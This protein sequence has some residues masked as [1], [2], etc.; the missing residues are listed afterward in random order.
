M[1]ITDNGLIAPPSGRHGGYVLVLLMLGYVLSFFDRQ[2]LVMM[3][4]PIGRDLHLTD[5]HF[6][7]LYGFA[8]AFF[9]TVVGLFFGRLVDSMHRPRLLAGAIILWSLATAACGLATN[10][11]ELFIARMMVGVGEA[12]LAPV[13]Y[14][15]IADLFQPQRR[16]R[17]FSIYAMGIYL[18]TGVAFILGGKLVGW[19]DALPPMSLPWNGEPL[20]GWHLA[21]LIAGVPGLVLALALMFV[22][23]ARPAR[24]AATPVRGA[25]F[26]SF[27]EHARRHWRALT[28]H[29]FGFAMHTGYGYAIAIWT[30]AFFLRHHHWSIGQVGLVLG[31]I[32]LTAGP[33]G[34]IA[35]G[36]LTDAWLK[37]GIKDA[38][39]RVGSL[40]CVAQLGAVALMVLSPSPILGVIG[41]ALAI[42]TMAATAGPAG[43]ALQQL[44]PATLRGQAGAFYTLVANLLG[45]SLVPLLVGLSTDRLFVDPSK[46]GLSLLAVGAF[47]LLLGAGLLW[48]GKDKFALRT[49]DAQV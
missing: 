12:A 49:D 36:V 1:Q 3:I 9:Y 11:T 25:T 37:R 35:G 41:A 26:G 33:L 2:I 14:S 10:F 48:L 38:Y 47:V 18:G 20:A 24:T 39:L 46:V 34:A 4:E 40:I 8:F 15:L 21:F 16:A 23:E 6:G 29:H 43:A 5:T 44:T 7:L 32:L 31:V 17:A 13:A 42:V 22:R 27:V 30:P 19:L 45:L 28:C